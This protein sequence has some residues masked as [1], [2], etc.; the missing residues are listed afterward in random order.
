LVGQVY[1]LV[2][3]AVVVVVNVVPRARRAGFVV[4]VVVMVE[5]IGAGV[6]VDVT[7]AGVTVGV[8]D[9]GVIVV[10]PLRV[11]VV[12]TVAGYMVS[13]SSTRRYLGSGWSK[14]KLRKSTRL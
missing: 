5:V 11:E 8:T 12:V 3:V 1:V 9:A 7:G 2:V 13:E 14:H 4:N 6:T 10:T